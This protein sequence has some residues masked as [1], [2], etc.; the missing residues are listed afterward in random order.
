M[1]YSEREI[2]FSVQHYLWILKIK[3]SSILEKALQC[4]LS[5]I[6]KTNSGE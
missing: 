2:T 5:F 1:G 4:T 6:W 3:V